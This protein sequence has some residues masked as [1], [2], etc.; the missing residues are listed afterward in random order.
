MASGIS[1]LVT[2]SK[3]SRSLDGNRDIDEGGKTGGCNA[4]SF[5]FVNV[6]L[7]LDQTPLGPLLGELPSS[8]LVYLKARQSIALMF[9]LVV[10]LFS[11]ARFLR[12]IL[13]IEKDIL[14]N[15]GVEPKTFALLARRSN[16]LS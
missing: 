15:V 14:A 4:P 7:R 6:P 13:H 11:R 9:T 5:N 16:Q 1:I 10:D 12:S 3:I 2:A 8:S